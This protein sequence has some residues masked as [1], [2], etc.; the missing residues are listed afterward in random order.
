MGQRLAEC[1]STGEQSIVEFERFFRYF[2]SFTLDLVELDALCSHGLPGVPERD[3]NAD[4]RRIDFMAQS[5]ARFTRR[6][7]PIFCGGQS[8]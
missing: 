4:K 3:V 6:V 2:A 5:C 7:M 1:G 8:D